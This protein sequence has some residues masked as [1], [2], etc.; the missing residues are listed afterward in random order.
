MKGP[1]DQEQM[2][3]ASFHLKAAIK[4]V[5]A[6]H[7]MGFEVGGQRN[8]WMAW[9]ERSRESLDEASVYLEVVNILGKE[10]ILDGDKP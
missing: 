1:P 10:P 4:A 9:I 2:R 6:I 7:K 3:E 8:E 5:S